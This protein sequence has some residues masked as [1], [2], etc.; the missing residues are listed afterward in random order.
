MRYIIEGM[1]SSE[2]VKFYHDKLKKKKIT[3]DLN[4]SRDLQITDKVLKL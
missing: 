2:G 3:P 4:L 1:S